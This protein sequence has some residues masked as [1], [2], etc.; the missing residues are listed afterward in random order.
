MGELLGN[1]VDRAI[2][3]TT[4]AAHPT[5]REDLRC[6]FQR[7]SNNAF[8]EAELSAI[9]GE[10]HH[11]LRVSEA[12]AMPS[13]P[14]DSQIPV[15]LSGDQLAVAQTVLKRFRDPELRIRVDLELS[16][17][18]RSGRLQIR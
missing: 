17:A 12:V 18:V 6:L 9:E 11:A 10:L 15:A 1:F 4:L 7:V 13:D 2:I 5:L 8:S 16:A 3:R 14:L